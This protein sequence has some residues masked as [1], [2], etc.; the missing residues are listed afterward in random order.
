MA[1]LTTDF[2]FSPVSIEDLDTIAA[3]ESLSFHPD[4]AASK[5]Q[6]EKRIGYAVQTDDAL[7]AVTRHNGELVGYITTT[8]TTAPLVTDESMSNH[9][10]SG[11]T[12]CLHG[13]C[14]APEYRGR[15]L[16]G[17]LMRHW[18]QQ[19]KKTNKY[20]RI[21][22]LSRPD[23]T[24]LY[25]SVGFKTLGKSEVVHGPDPWYDCVLDI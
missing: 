1:K 18:I 12:V 14:T 23:L 8:L 10:P 22:L 25:E 6:L 4:E 13:V 7:M 9:D 20:T 15:G 5:E 21:A 2:E 19:L 24:G 17:A 16:A 3:L 11:K